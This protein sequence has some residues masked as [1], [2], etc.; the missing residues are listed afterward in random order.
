MRTALTPLLGDKNAKAVLDVWSPKLNDGTGVITFLVRTLTSQADEILRLS[1]PD[2][3]IFDTPLDE[4]LRFKH[5]W[6]KQEG[7]PLPQTEVEAI[8]AAHEHF[9][10]FSKQG[11]WALKVTP[12]AFQTIRPN[13]VKVVCLPFLSKVFL[14]TEFCRKLHWNVEVD[15]NSRRFRGHRLQWVVRAGSPPPVFS[16]SCCAHTQG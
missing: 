4:A 8:M 3:I 1:R 5:V 14:R 2:R 10:A 13:W 7:S 9:G 15:V 12:A 11:V 6:L 16:T